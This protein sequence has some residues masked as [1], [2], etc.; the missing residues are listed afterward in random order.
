MFSEEKLFF[1]LHNIMKKMRSLFNKALLPFG[2]THS[3]IRILMMVY[4]SK[5]CRQ[6]DLISRL[7]VDRSNVGRSL[8][9]L[10]RMNYIGRE[11]DQSDARRYRIYITEKGKNIRDRLLK[12]RD[13]IRENVVK[14]AT[15]E[16]IEKL[17][18]LLEKID[19]NLSKDM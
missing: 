16:E 13:N 1:S 14:S 4:E 9:K 3:E 12:I 15:I 18:K 5:D 8:K 6:E 17:S 7:E 2:I 10:E 11:K 19:Q